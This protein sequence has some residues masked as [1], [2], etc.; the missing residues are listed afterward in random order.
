MK[1]KQKYHGLVNR[2]RVIATLE[3]KANITGFRWTC[4]QKM[5]KDFIQKRSK[6]GYFLHYSLTKP[7]GILNIDRCEKVAAVFVDGWDVDRAWEVLDP[8]VPAGLQVKVVTDVP[9]SVIAKLAEV[10]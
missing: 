3:D 10:C 7:A 2:E 6:K 8:L 9:L 5:P 4:P 1:K